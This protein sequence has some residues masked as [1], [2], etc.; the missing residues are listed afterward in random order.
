MTLSDPTDLAVYAHRKA[1]KSGVFF[2]A[3][4]YPVICSI[5]QTSVH[6]GAKHCRFCNRCVD[7]FDHHCKWLN[8]CIGSSNY[9]LFLLLIC[10]LLVSELMISVSI[11]LFFLDSGE[12]QCQEYAGWDCQP[13]AILLVVV[14]LLIAVL[15]TLAMTSLVMLHVWL[16]KCKKMTTYEYIISKRRSTKYIENTPQN[17]SGKTGTHG[18]SSSFSELPL[19]E[20]VRWRKSLTVRPET[21]GNYAGSQITSTVMETRKNREER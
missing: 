14:A 6:S 7:G 15:V 9:R 11:L 5:C 16:R 2:D 4:S 13:L 8:N 20:E 1:Q 3:S 19:I 12:K 10:I 17:Q 18:P 21:S